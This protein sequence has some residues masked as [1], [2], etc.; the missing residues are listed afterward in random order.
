[1]AITLGSDTQLGG[2]AM[3]RPAASHS[4]VDDVLAD[5]KVA[6][7][8]DLSRRRPLSPNGSDIII[9]I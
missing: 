6:P 4:G 1:M 9:G 7:K 2:S 3:T 8:F 5:G